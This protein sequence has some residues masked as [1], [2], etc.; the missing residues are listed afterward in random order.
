ML[1]NLVPCTSQ[2]RRST[3][4]FASAVSAQELEVQLQRSVPVLVTE[5]TWEDGSHGCNAYSLDTYSVMPMLQ[6]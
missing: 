2:N 1:M 4:S 5:N 3:M 6:V